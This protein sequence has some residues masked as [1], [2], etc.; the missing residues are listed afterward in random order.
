MHTLT[1]DT[2][3]A[4]GALDLAQRASCRC[5]R[6]RH[7]VGRDRVRDPSLVSP[8]DFD[9]DLAERPVAHPW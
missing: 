6:Q 7:R 5:D 1:L 4:F 2:Q 8:P 3:S 9:V